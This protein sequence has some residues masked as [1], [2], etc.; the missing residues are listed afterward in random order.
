MIK[1]YGHGL[2]IELINIEFK[3]Q[4]KIIEEVILLSQAGNIKR[5]PRNSF[6]IQW[7]NGKGV[8]T[9]DDL[10]MSTISTNTI[11]NLLLLT[12]NVKMFKII[13]DEIPVGK[14]ASKGQ[15]LEL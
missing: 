9:K 4:D 5:I 6:K 11:D 1:K 12:K 13:L 8:K 15:M 3:T 14:N 7:K 10:I 2:L